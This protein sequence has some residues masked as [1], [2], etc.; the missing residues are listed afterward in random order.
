MTGF[1]TLHP[2]PTLTIH[3]VSELG[4]GKYSVMKKIPIFNINV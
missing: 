1:Q 3:F 2:S 4:L